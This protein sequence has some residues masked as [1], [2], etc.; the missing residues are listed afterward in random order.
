MKIIDNYEK[1]L[2]F[3]CDE[4]NNNET[5]QSRGEHASV[6]VQRF[7]RSTGVRFGDA[8]SQKAAINYLLDQGFV[9]I[10]SINGIR[11]GGVFYYSHSRIK[12]TLKGIDFIKQKRSPGRI[13][14]KIAPTL[15]EITGRFLKGILGK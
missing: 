2:G 4:F 6:L 13:V 7:S 10:V 15:A 3:I 8:N 5:F 1:L 14:Q 12:P 9:E 11:M